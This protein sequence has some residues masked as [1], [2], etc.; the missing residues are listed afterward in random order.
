M[1]V[2]TSHF[3]NGKYV[4]EDSTITG[5]AGKKDFIG[6]ALEK[7]MMNNEL[8]FGRRVLNVIEDNGLSF[9]HMPSGIDTMTIVVNTKEFVPHEQE[10]LAGIHRAVNP[11]RIDLESDLA[12][13]AIVGRGMKASRG[14]AAKIFN[15]LAKKKINIKMIDQ[16]SSEQNIIVGVR[17]V[18]FNEAIKAIYDAFVERED[19]A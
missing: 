18:Y 17:N 1:I 9:E 3:F 2:P 14:T 4:R 5:V 10:I 13:I 7:S 8:G 12:L 19:L 6:I 15:A 16:G 11:D